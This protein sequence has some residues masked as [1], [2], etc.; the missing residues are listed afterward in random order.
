M[1]LAPT[2]QQTTR[3]R[4]HSDVTLKFPFSCVKAR[5]TRQ[6]IAFTAGSRSETAIKG[7]LHGCLSST[8][9]H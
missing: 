1:E 2:I 4:L 5:K 7:L 9:D 8:P 6:S 3:T